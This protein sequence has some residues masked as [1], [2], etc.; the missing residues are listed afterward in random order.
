[1][2]TMKKTK[3]IEEMPQEEKVKIYRMLKIRKT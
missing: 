2:I 3:K 1:M